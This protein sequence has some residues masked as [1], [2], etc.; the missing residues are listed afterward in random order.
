MNDR[1]SPRWEKVYFDSTDTLFRM[2]INGGSL[3]KDASIRQGNFHISMTFVPD[4]VCPCCGHEMLYI[5]TP[6]HEG[7]NKK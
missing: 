1:I 5:C 6:C 7:M 2:K 3:Y 4:R